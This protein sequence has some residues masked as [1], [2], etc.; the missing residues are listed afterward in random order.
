MVQK[1]KQ[2][3]FAWLGA[4]SL[5][6]GSS[7][8]AQAQTVIWGAGSGNAAQETQGT[9][10]ATDSAFGGTNWATSNNNGGSWTWSSNGRAVGPNSVA[11]V[12]SGTGRWI[13]SPSVSNGAAIFDSDYFYDAT[14]VYPQSGSLSLTNI[15]L[16]GYADSLISLRFYT[17]Y[18][19]FETDT[20]TVAFSADGGTTWITTNVYPLGAGSGNRANYNGWIMVNISSALAGATN[21]SNCQVRFRFKGDSYFWA[22]D[23]LSFITAP[24]YDVAIEV[25][26]PGA[27]TTLGS[28]YSTVRVSGNYY[29]PLSQVSADEYGYGARLVNK[30]ASDLSAAQLFAKVEYNA[31]GSW[32]LEAFDSLSIVGTLSANSGSFIDTT[33][34]FSN[35]WLPVRAGEYR[36]T[37]FVKQ[38]QGQDANPG[39]DTLIQFFNV[40]DSLA[41]YYS[42]TPLSTDL[43]PTIDNATFPAATTGNLVSLFE[44][45]SMFYFPQGGLMSM[46]S[47]RFRVYRYSS[48][49]TP[50]SF[51]SGVVTV[52]LSKF[53]DLDGNGILST[54]PNSGELELVAIGSDTVASTISNASGQFNVSVLL[55]D[56]NNGVAPHLNDSTIYLV[57]I[58]QT[59]ASGMTNAS[60]SQ[61]YAYGVGTYSFNYAMNAG[62]IAPSPV[63]VGEITS[64]GASATDEW[65]WIGFGADQEPSIGLFL[66]DLRTVAV[67]ELASNVSSMELFPN[68]TSGVLNVKVELKEM[69]TINYI[70]T[71]INGRIVRMSTSKN[72]QSEVTSFNVSDLASGVYFISVRT[73]KGVSTQRFVK[74]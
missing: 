13:T 40:T 44:Y 23:D 70:M 3:C 57:S 47:V 64:A 59:N 68:P 52:R 48:Q 9:F 58:E 8:L 39:N 24:P 4:A 55:A 18:M 34:I 12:N 5:I 72:V 56:I 29:Q 7:S 45:G 71:D 30:G 51:T 21:L 53:E 31:G 37:Y 66:T 22:V 6:A 49:V 54:D 14:G 2:N 17:S 63:R 27:G 69:G 67:R 50:A 74:E 20:A 28:T 41:P 35:G 42:K 38:T 15:D 36:V 61:I 33:G 65:N 26:I 25:P 19:D 46:D 16:T 1:F 11:W 10:A 62:T 73:N 60:G 32:S 43:Y